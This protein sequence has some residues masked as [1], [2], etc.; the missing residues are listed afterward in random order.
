M[1]LPGLALAWAM[2]SATLL[3]GKSLRTQSRF[4]TLATCPSSTKS[5]S[6]SNRTPG[7][8]L[9]VGGDAGRHD[10][11]LTAVAWTLGDPIHAE[12][13]TGAGNILDHARHLPQRT[14]PIGDHAADDILGAARRKT[15]D[16]FD[17]QPRG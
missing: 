14:Q 1:S 17:G 15:H 2:S 16:E 9:L 10:A 3:T 12:I 11:D 13:A 7:V 8:K 4:G 6:G 5:F